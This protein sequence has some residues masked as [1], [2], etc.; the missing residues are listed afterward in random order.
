MEKLSA[1][2]C[3]GNGSMAIQDKSNGGWYLFALFIASND[4]PTQKT[5]PEPPEP[6]LGSR[7]V[8]IKLNSDGT[9]VEEMVMTPI[10]RNAVDM[11]MVDPAGGFESGLL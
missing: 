3:H 6:Y 8:R 10:G 4:M 11:D 9:G 2:I 7:L 1:Y 5:E